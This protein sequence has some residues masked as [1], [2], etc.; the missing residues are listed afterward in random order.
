MTVRKR[1]IVLGAALALAGCA[2]PSQSYRSTSLA[3]T[4]VDQAYNECQFEADKAAPMADLRQSPLAL[5][6]QQR[7]IIDS[8]MRAKGF[9]R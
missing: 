6:V 7:Q 3:T 5:A 8:C 1:A 9:Q 4:N 2:P